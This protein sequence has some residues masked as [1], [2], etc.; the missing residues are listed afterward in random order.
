MRL[1][2]NDPTDFEFSPDRELR[3]RFGGNE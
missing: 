3:R 2:L 1:A